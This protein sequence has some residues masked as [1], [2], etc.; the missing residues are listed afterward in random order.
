MSADSRSTDEVQNCLYRFTSSTFVTR[1]YMCGNH[2]HICEDCKC[3]RCIVLRW[4]RN[5]NCNCRLPSPRH[6][7]S[8]DGRIRKKRL[9]CRHEP[10]SSAIFP[11]E[12]CFCE[13]PE[14]THDQIA[15]TYIENRTANSSDEGSCSIEEE[16][17]SSVEQDST[18][19]N[20]TNVHC[21]RDLRRI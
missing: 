17:D 5:P 7:L 16:D 10:K 8:L 9:A 12:F 11:P 1:M 15:L 19:S 3:L 18:H 21:F 13:L 4:V 6:G 2:L 14:K 20:A